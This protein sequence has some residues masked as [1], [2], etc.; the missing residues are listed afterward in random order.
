VGAV[1]VLEHEAA[2]LRAKILAREA[3]LAAAR[4]KAAEAAPPVAPAG[5]AVALQDAAAKQP[6]TDAPAPPAPA[7]ADEKVRADLTAAQEREAEASA[8]AE[9][10]GEAVRQARL[11]LED[12]RKA[13]ADVARATGD[14]QKLEADRRDLLRRIESL[15]AT[16]ATSVVPVKPGGDAVSV[17]A[18][19][20]DRRF[21]WMLVAGA[22][23][24]AVCSLMMW[25]SAH[26][27][28]SL[29]IPDREN[30]FEAPVVGA[31][32]PAGGDDDE[33]PLAV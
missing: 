3:E 19:G 16:L 28:Q 26:G 24:V 17:S 25:V 8:A 31:A 7:A 22:S 2:D 23:I 10:S 32:P 9:K 30:P 1:A 12:A 6:A 21:L 11:D 14:W 33:R 15:K 18:V 27:T 4:A 13:A 20:E 5:D 29:A